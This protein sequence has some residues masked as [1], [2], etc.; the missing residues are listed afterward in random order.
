MKILKIGGVLL[1]IAS[2]SMIYYYGFY[3]DPRFALIQT[4]DRNASH[5][6]KALYDNLQQISEERILFGHQDGLAYGVE[7][8]DWHQ[9]RSDVK[10]VCGKYPSVI[11]W[12]LGKL[13]QSPFN[14]DSVYFDQM[15]DWMKEVYRMGGINTVSWH[16]DNFATGG[17]AWDIEDSLNVVASILPGGKNH[18]AYQKKLDLFADFMEDLEVGFIFKEKIPIVFRP[19]HEHTG[20]W[21]WWGANYCTPEEYKSLWHYTVAYLRDKKGLHNI[22]Y[23]YSPDIFKD[24]EHYLER[25]PGDEWVDILGLDDY[26]DVGAHGNINNLTTRLRT[27]VKLAETKGKIA[28]LTETGLESIPQEKWWTDKLLNAIKSDP[29]AK[30]IAWLLVWRNDRPTHHYAPYPRHASASNFIEFSKDPVMLFEDKLPALYK[31]S[32]K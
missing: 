27:I 28:A 16:F 26:H 1:L 19:F 9:K 4:A 29:E 3:E 2:I 17:N 12:E 18:Q 20:N 21:F 23:A 22:L 25:Y 10:D 13:G 8:K 32:K 14:I 11:G 24:E 31:L 5:P 7:W 15:K 6:T 30:K